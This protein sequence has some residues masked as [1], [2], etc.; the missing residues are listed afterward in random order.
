MCNCIDYDVFTPKNILPRKNFSL[1]AEK[2]IIL[3]GSQ[4][5][6]DKFKDNLKILDILKI[7]D[8]NS[9]LIT[10]GKYKLKI[11]GLLMLDMY[12]RKNILSDL[13]FNFLIYF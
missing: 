7:F 9:K 2:F 3:I 12:K 11:K 4:K 10:F 8:K 1:P 5:L 13:S 6:N